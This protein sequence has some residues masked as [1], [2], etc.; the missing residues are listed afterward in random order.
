VARV[1][2]VEDDATFGALLQAACGRWE[3]ESVLV[4][5]GTEAFREVAGS[6]EE[7][8]LIL[9]D[10]QMPRMPGKLFLERVAD[11]VR[12]Q[13]PVVVLSAERL[14]LDAL[15][16]VR[17]WLFEVVQKGCDLSHLHDI[18][19]RALEERQ[20][21]KAKQEEEQLAERLER[22]IGF[23]LHQNEALYEQVRVDHLTGLPTRLRLEEEF[24]GFIAADSRFRGTFVLALCDLD[25]FRRINKN[26]G[27]A[28]GD[29]AL[30]HCAG[31]MRAAMRAGDSIYRYGGDEFVLLVQ[32][33]DLAEGTDAVERIRM[34]VALAH[35]ASFGEH[36]LPPITLS[37]GVIDSTARDRP[38]LQDLLGDA[39]LALG[40]A[41]DAGGNG[42]WPSSSPP[43]GPDGTP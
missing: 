31:L 17:S 25:G 23:L 42:V 5:D 10:L 27:Y 6:G 37:A 26:L 19:V 20:R 35:G 3:Y 1:L 32:A 11:L 39:T 13:I 28:G 14:L 8:D 41:K 18:V 2:L 29:A 38:T 21:I 22:K 40:R 9:C 16:D 33:R 36:Q 7:Y 12:D 4:K 15:G 34:K 24:D 43:P 30:R